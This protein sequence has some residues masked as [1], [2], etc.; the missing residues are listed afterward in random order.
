MVKVSGPGRLGSTKAVKK[1][2]QTKAFLT[3][4]IPPEGITVRFLDEPEDFYG[5]YQHWLAEGPIPCVEGDCAGCNSDNPDQRRK[6]FRYLA[7]VYSVDESKVEAVEIPKS[8]VEQLVAYFEKYGTLL[9]RDYDLSKSGT[10]MMGTK[11]HVSPDSPSRLKLDRFK[12]LDLDKILTAM[13]LD[14]EDEDEDDEE[15]EEPVTRKTKRRT[16]A[17][18]SR[19]EEDDPWDDDDE[20]DDEPPARLRRSAT[21]KPVAKRTTS[22]SRKS[23]RINRK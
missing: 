14:S 19:D 11:Y 16:T 1:S 21:R 23:I 18:R 20:E 2:L 6:S 3:K 9:D 17:T 12:K 5:F 13:A 15:D 7:N 22:T 4:Q 8:A 10:G